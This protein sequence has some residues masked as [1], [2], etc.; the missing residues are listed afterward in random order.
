MVRCKLCKVTDKPSKS[1]NCIC[2][3]DIEPD[4][5]ILSMAVNRCQIK[6]VPRDVSF[7]EIETT[8]NIHGKAVNTG[9]RFFSLKVVQKRSIAND[10]INTVFCGK[11]LI[12]P[13]VFT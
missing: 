7:S 10:K 12:I 4:V 5:S 8:V 13:K 11:E 9:Y 1:H 2:N 3:Q 6:S